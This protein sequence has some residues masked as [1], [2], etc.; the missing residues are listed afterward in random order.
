MSFLFSSTFWGVCIILFGVT[1]ILERIFKVKISFFKILIG[2]I[3]IF[4]GIHLLIGN[5]NI[6]LKLS[7]QLNSDQKG[8][9]SATFVNQEINLND[10][11]LNENNELMIKTFCSNL[12]LK[13]PDSL[14]Y[15]FEVN[16]V[17]S[18]TSLPYVTDP[19][20]SENTHELEGK[21]SSLKPVTIKLR[22]ILSNVEVIQETVEIEQVDGF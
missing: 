20:I 7:S 2:I 17:L 15:K 21:N 13:V 10:Y 3:F 5:R 1:L 8:Q 18:E 6:D 11:A 12:T 16:N 22:A 4:I 19:P 14:S 9:I